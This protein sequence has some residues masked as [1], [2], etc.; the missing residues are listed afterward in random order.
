MTKNLKLNNGTLGEI[1]KVFSI[2]LTTA[3][4][5]AEQNRYQNVNDKKSVKFGFCEKVI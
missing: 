3:T 2:S 1:P 5:S 4:I